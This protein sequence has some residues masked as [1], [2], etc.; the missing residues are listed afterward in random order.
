MKSTSVR[1]AYKGKQ[2]TICFATDAKYASCLGVAIQSI[3]C[4]ATEGKRY[5]ICVLHTGLTQERVRQIERMS[6]E[7]ISIR[8]FRVDE[9]VRPKEI[10]RL[11]ATPRFPKEACFRFLIPQLFRGKRKVLYMDCDVV[12]TRDVATLYETRLTADQY[13]GV[14]HDTF[15]RYSVEKGDGY[16]RE[17]LELAE[18][19]D[20]FQSG[21]MLMN[22]TALER[23]GIVRKLKLA[24]QQTK[25]LRFPDQDI[26]NMVCAGHVRYLDGRWNVEYH[27][28]LCAPDY[29]EVMTPEEVAEYER[30]YDD[31]WILHF[32]GSRKPWVNPTY[33]LSEIFWKYARQSPFYE[34]LLY[35]NILL[36]AR[37]E[38]TKALTNREGAKTV[39]I[40]PQS[41]AAKSS[42]VP[43]P[44]TGRS[45]EASHK[46]T[47]NTSS[48]NRIKTTNTDSE[49]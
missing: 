8:F 25:D 24:M 1:A 18:P 23:D 32:C 40:E 41:P 13:F 16:Y 31:P 19:G 30:N 35:H 47:D 38:F 22:L 42:T 27:V 28:P 21:I 20:Y 44:R 6:R 37:R 33:P 48:K 3:I 36:N 46:K 10:E 12:V 4:H 29:G 26:L 34:E 39:R 45:R 17:E 7:N 14:V 2:V 15:V 49:S 43:T 11:H 9:M 5:D